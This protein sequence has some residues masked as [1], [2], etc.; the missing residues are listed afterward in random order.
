MPQRFDLR[1]YETGGHQQA[2]GKLVRLDLLW[3]DTLGR[4]HTALADVVAAID[5]HVSAR[6]ELV[7][8]NMMAD[9]MCN[10]E[11]ASNLGLL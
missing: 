6:F 9:F 1:T 11:S 8:K 7:A 2:R 4:P 10:R 3:I 5:V